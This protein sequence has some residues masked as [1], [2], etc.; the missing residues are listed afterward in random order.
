MAGAADD[1]DEAPSPD[2]VLRQLDD[3]V[4]LSSVK[5]HVRS[6]YA[7]LMLDQQRRNAGVR[8]HHATCAD[9]PSTLNPHARAPLPDARAV[10]I[11]PAHDIPRQSRNGKDLSGSVRVVQQAL[12]PSLC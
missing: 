4:G 12:L 3:I 2:R 10:L 5:A 6:L 1:E 9:P 8:R 7:Q 11:D